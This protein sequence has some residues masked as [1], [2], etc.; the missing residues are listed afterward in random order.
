MMDA[1]KWGFGMRALVLK[2]A[3]AFGL[4][5]S[6]AASAAPYLATY[7]GTVSDSYAVTATASGDVI[8][9]TND[10]GAV[11]GSFD[12][13]T[14]TLRLLYDTSVGGLADYPYTK[15]LEGSAPNSPI[16]WA[17]MTINGQTMALPSISHSIVTVFNFSSVGFPDS[18]GFGHQAQRYT[19]D[20]SLDG[21]IAISLF[22]ISVD[23]ILNQTFSGAPSGGDVQYS[24]GYFGFDSYDAATDTYRYAGGDLRATYLT[25]AALPEP[26]SWTLM[27]LGFAGLGAALRRPRPVAA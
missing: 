17:A 12:G 1:G 22:N 9:N 25:V 4:A 3:V 21:S 16:S 26:G 18:R 13:A 10:F 7:T 23:A 20:G 5:M 15:N 27:L 2:L 14:F 8:G 11:N 19:G 6:S 24:T